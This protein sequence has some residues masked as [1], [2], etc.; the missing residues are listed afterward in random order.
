MDDLIEYPTFSLTVHIGPYKYSVL[1]KEGEK[2][3]KQ[4][5]KNSLWETAQLASFQAS[6]EMAMLSEVQASLPPNPIVSGISIPCPTG[7]DPGGCP[8]RLSVKLALV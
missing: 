5:K 2:N 3:K 6:W 7:V 1:T 4:E 8:Q